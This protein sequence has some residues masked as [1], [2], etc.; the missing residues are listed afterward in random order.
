M[1]GEDLQQ[2]VDEERAVEAAFSTF[3][4]GLYFVFIDDVQVESLDAP[5]SLRPESELLFLRLVPLAGG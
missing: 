5:V 4:D 2:S 1:G 3:R